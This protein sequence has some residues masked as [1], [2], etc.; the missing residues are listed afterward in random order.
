[1]NPDADFFCM[2]ITSLGFRSGSFELV[3]CLEVLEHVP[4]PLVALAEL[5]RVSS[6][7][8]LISVPYE[9]FFRLANFLRGRRVRQLGN[10]PEHLHHW[11]PRRFQAFLSRSFH[12]RELHN[13]FPWLLALCE[14]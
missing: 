6:R 5:R 11:G 13:A 4:D 12:V 2:E 9:P 8:C 1:L 7:S 10:H 3:L 14:Q